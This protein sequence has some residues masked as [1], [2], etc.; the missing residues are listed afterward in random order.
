MAVERTIEV[1]LAKAHRHCG[2]TYQPGDK[3]KVSE[4]ERDFLK[5]QGVLE[6]GQPQNTVQTPRSP[7][8][9][10]QNRDA[11]NQGDK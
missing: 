4:D 10:A 9:P 3:I 7:Q 8:A 5:K 1:T 11:R 2:E 6:E